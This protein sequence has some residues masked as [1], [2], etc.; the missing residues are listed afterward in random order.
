MI[1]KKPKQKIDNNLFP[2]IIVENKIIK[3]VT[4]CKYLGV[5]LDEDL[6]FTHHIDNVLSKI[7]K[8]CGAFYKLRFK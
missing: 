7:R 8:M 1:F 3:H 5:T 2:D 6:T 4:N